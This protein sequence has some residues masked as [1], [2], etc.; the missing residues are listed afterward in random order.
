MWPP[1]FGVRLLR[2]CVSAGRKSAW[3]LQSHALK[4]HGTTCTGPLSLVPLQT[5]PQTAMSSTK[6]DGPP[7]A[8]IPPPKLHYV[9]NCRSCLTALVIL[10]HTACSYGGIGRNVYQ[11]SL[12]SQ[13]SSTALV[14][15]NGFNQSFVSTI[16]ST[17][18][19]D[20][21]VLTGLSSSW[22]HTCTWVATSPAEHWRGSLEKASSRIDYIVSAFQHSL[23]R[24]LEHHYVPV[25]FGSGKEPQ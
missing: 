6:G 7:A 22:A 23:T 11:S 24:P 4:H 2:R 14:G 19:R 13:A 25:S 15:L 21:D 1:E 18:A 20:D 16:S 10:H 9:D 5:L 3:C 17:V 12:H 8:R